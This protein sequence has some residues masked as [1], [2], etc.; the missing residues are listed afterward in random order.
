MTTTMSRELEAL[1]TQLAQWRKDGGGGRGK[2][3]PEAVWQQAAAVARVDGIHA[4]ARAGRLNVERLKAM[5]AAMSAPARA[6]SEP[7]KVLSAPHR[8]SP[9][10]GA[11]LARGKKQPLAKPQGAQFVSVQMSPV[12]P[13]RAMTIELTSRSGDR[14]RI[15]STDA[16]D[17][18][19]VVQS[20]W[21]KQP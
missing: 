5:V 6:E 3:I 19:V 20:F 16:I 9:R 4:T 17:L 11:A 8:P 2:R 7:A 12:A 21:S 13:R 14:M 10:E 15:E 18:A 1:C